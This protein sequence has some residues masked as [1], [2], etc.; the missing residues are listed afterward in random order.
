MKRSSLFYN[1]Y[2]MFISFTPTGAWTLTLDDKWYDFSEGHVINCTDGVI[3]TIDN[4]TSGIE[5]ETPSLVYNESY[6]GGYCISANVVLLKNSA[7]MSHI[8]Y[9]NPNTKIP[10]YRLRNS[11]DPNNFNITVMWKYVDTQQKFK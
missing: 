1:Y 3:E 7:S 9:G 11:I 2:E 4:L 10:F 5:E 8:Y 6:K